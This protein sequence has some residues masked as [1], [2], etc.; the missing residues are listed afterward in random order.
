MD[1]TTAQCS[2]VD[3]AIEVFQQ[4]F[5]NAVGIFDN[6]PSH[7]KYSS[8]GLNPSDMNV[9]PGGKQPLIRDTSWNGTHQ[10]FLVTDDQK[11]MKIVLQKRG[12]NTSGLNAAKMRHTK[13][14]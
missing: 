11:G 3:E 7:K 12:I 8:D 13:S 2:Q 10:W 14:T 4:I 1:I 5:P 6:A 9:H